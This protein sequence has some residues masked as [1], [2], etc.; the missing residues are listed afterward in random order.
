MAS[1]ALTAYDAYVDSRRGTER[2][3]AELRAKGEEL[4]TA[5]F[6]EMVS[7]VDVEGDKDVVANPGDTDRAARQTLFKGWWSEMRA[8]HREI[9]R[10]L[11]S[12]R[13]E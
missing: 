9:H 6:Q 3:K 4:F 13:A 10:R 11:E 5:V 7:L 1:P 12:E 8:V 2:D